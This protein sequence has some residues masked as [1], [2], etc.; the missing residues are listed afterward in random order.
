MGNFSNLAADVAT[1]IELVI[2]ELADRHGIYSRKEPAKEI[3]AEDEIT[4]MQI[5]F[6][7]VLSG[8]PIFRHLCSVNNL[9]EE[10]TV[11]IEIY[12]R[13]AM[14]KRLQE[15]PLYDTAVISFYDPPSSRTPG[16]YGPLDYGQKCSAVYPICVPDIDYEVLP[17]YGL[18]FETYLPEAKQ[19]AL[20]IKTAAAHRWD[21]VCQCEYGQ[22]RSAACA[23][24][25]KEYYEKDGI[26]IFA[27]YRYYPNQLIFNKVLDALKT[28]N[29]AEDVQC[30]SL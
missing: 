9:Q 24:A 10:L 19:L 29:S 15:G 8:K 3:P 21:I 12:S 17:E 25:I 16:D 30:A 1:A 7:A 5:S 6:S 18:T 11:K 20:Y 26:S 28:V 4:G 27:D 14:E 2:R 23:A 13:T 22:S